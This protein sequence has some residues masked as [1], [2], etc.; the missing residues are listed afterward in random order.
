MRPQEV[1]FSAQVS[2]G[3]FASFPLQHKHQHQQQQHHPPATTADPTMAFSPKHIPENELEK[4]LDNF[5]LEPSDT[6]AQISSPS[7][8]SSSESKPVVIEASDNI[9]PP[10]RPIDP[11]SA[12]FLSPPMPS[13]PVSAQLLPVNVADEQDRAD[14]GPPLPPRKRHPPAS[15]R[16]DRSHTLSSMLSVASSAFFNPKRASFSSTANYDLLLSRIDDGAVSTSRSSI[17][18]SNNDAS[19][20][21]SKLL[22]KSHFDSIRNSMELSNVTSE[23]ESGDIDWELWSQIVDDYKVFAK[24]NV[25]DLSLAIASGIPEEIRG[26][27]WQIVSASKSQSLEGLYSSI[28]T[29]TA[30][31]EAEIQADIEK[32]AVSDPQIINKKLFGVLKGYSLFDPEVGYTEDLARIAVPLVENVSEVEAFCLL[33]KLLKDY[34]L[35]EFLT[36][37]KPGLQ[38]RLYQFDR[39]LEDTLPDVHIHLSKQGI[40]SSMY[41]SSWFVTLFSR[42]F[43]D[44]PAVLERIYDVIMTEGIEA[45]L[46]FA[47][48]IVRRNATNILTLEF[49]DLLHFLK[50][51][52][53]EIYYAEDEES[54]DR[55]FRIND[56]IADG[57]EVKILPVTLQ[58]YNNEYRELH[59]LERERIEEVEN[60]RGTKQALQSKIDKLEK[61]VQTLANEHAMVSKD[62][63]DEHQ[64]TKKLYELNQE[65]NET[66]NVLELEVHE[67]LAGLGDTGNPAK[68]LEDLRV[69]NSVLKAEQTAREKQLTDLESELITSKN[70][71]EDVSIF[72]FFFFFFHF[73]G[74]VDRYRCQCCQCY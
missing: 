8:P 14:G 47:V 41:A 21:N 59:A 61:T 48:G 23:D 73:A 62:L 12:N 63:F 36:Q 66:K 3:H 70:N 24:H 26:I 53:L 50:Q 55:V 20:L 54:G 16:R 6:H 45:L 72:F 1:V 51:E 11:V 30:P 42:T 68:E 5:T 17:S 18:S 34:K 39:I 71:L 32:L 9:A 10:P 58:K 44:E 38:V 40:R 27:I 69:Q 29:E 22:L 31:A 46:R 60:L 43:V 37:G 65:L 4:R 64:K 7:R 33:V 49:E 2:K 52:L 15:L 25:I 19:L 67:K 74:S 35:R 56:F 57:Y 28:I 13:G